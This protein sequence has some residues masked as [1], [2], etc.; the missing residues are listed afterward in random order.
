M[1]NKKKIEFYELDVKVDL[2]SNLITDNGDYD[3]DLFF[4]ILLFHFFQSLIQNNN[5]KK[6]EI[7]NQIPSTENTFFFVFSF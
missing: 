7:K 2:D 1:I 6:E 3:D 5:N 4:L